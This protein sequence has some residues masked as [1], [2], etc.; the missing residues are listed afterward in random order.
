M[1]DPFSS[2]HSSG[3]KNCLQYESPSQRDEQIMLNTDFNTRR[4]ISGTP[5]SES[6]VSSQSYLRSKIFEAQNSSTETHGKIA[7]K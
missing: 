4:P 6:F 7:V 3:A 5:L 1:Q 2:K